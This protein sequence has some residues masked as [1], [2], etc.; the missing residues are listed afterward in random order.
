MRLVGRHQS[1][2][3]CSGCECRWS[4]PSS[5]QWWLI[6][7]AGSE[8]PSHGALWS[9]ISAA[10]QATVVCRTACVLN[11]LTAACE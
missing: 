3:P 7:H 1:P 9:A 8:N 2:V 4:S 11:G 10:G 6:R 5:P